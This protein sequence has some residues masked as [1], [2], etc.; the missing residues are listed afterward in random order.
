MPVDKFGRTTGK[1]HTHTHTVTRVITADAKP[2]NKSDDLLLNIGDDQT[3][4]LG[5]DDLTA[6][7]SFVV[8]LGDNDNTISYEKSKGVMLNTKNDLTVSTAGRPVFRFGSANVLF[9]DV[10]CR[11]A[12][13]IKDLPAP[14][15]DGDAVNKEYLMSVLAAQTSPVLTLRGKLPNEPLV[16]IVL[17]R[18]PDGSKVPIVLSLYIEKESGRWIHVMTSEFSESFKH[19]SLFVKGL[20]LCCSFT[21]IA[22]VHLWE[23]NYVLFYVYYNESSSETRF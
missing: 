23:R 7:R 3:R 2:L 14:V 18:V 10:H 15:D 5:C 19:F 17:H 21:N 13:A 22:N 12:H 16:E 20:A 1:A 9:G 4:A 11:R 8:K 6:G